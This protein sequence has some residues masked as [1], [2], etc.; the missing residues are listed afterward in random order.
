M[1]MQATVKTLKQHSILRPEMGSLLL[2][3]AVAWGAAGAVQAQT[4]APAAASPASP[5]SQMSSGSTAGAV[6]A[7]KATAK[8]A[9]AAFVRADVDKDGKLSRQEAE[10]LPELAARFEQIDT[11]HDGYI[12]RA[13]FTKATGS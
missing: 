13:E 1:T 10:S 2:A 5:P 6:P 11:N 9:E 8:E 3:A 12:S 7:N 4:A